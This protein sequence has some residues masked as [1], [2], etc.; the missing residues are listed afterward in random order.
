MEHCEDCKYYTLLFDDGSYGVCCN[1]ESHFQG[2]T[3]VSWNSCDSFD[4]M[5]ENNNGH[6]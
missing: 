5:R 3:V 6:E 1:E 2:K 4:V